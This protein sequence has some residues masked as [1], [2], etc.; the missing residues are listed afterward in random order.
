MTDQKKPHNRN[1]VHT[2]IEL[3]WNPST[4]SF[5]VVEDQWYW[6]GGAWSLAEH[7]AANI[8]QAEYRWRDDDS[9]ETGASWLEVVDTSHDF[10][11]TSGNVQARIRFTLQEDGGADSNPTAYTLQFQINGGGYADVLIDSTGVIYFNSG[12]LTDGE[13]TTSQLNGTGTFISGECSEDAITG[14]L[15][16]TANN[17]TEIEYTVEFVSAELTNGDSIDF[18]LTNTD[19]QTIDGNATITKGAAPVNY[20]RTLEST[21]DIENAIVR[22]IDFGGEYTRS[23]RSSSVVD[24][25]T[26][27]VSI[28]HIV[29]LLS[30]A[31]AYDATIRTITLGE[32]ILE[33]VLTSSVDT[34]DKIVAGVI[35]ERLLTDN[36]DIFDA[37]LSAVTV[38]TIERVIGSSIDV[39]DQQQAYE[40]KVRHL[41]STLFLEDILR[42]EALFNRLVISN[43]ELQDA[44]SRFIGKEIFVVLADTLNIQDA[45]DVSYNLT[46]AMLSLVDVLDKIGIEALYN[47]S[48]QDAAQLEDLVPISVERTRK[49][50]DSLGV[51]DEAQISRELNKVMLDVLSISDL[52]VRT[53]LVGPEEYLRVLTSN[54]GILDSLLR[55]LAEAPTI[56]A[57]LLTDNTV[58]TDELLRDYLSG[59]QILEFILV[60]IEQEDVQLD[61]EIEHIIIDIEKV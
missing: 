16:V 11:V 53:L 2:R 14:S 24:Q 29:Q 46:R 58:L 4:E 42:G 21:A 50:V 26:L 10:D 56:R 57:R 28:E 13:V 27:H 34:Y 33:R 40:N 31:S 12:N 15:S 6:Y 38:P 48:A 47:R 20:E 44:V 32:V 49:F 17:H 60:A 30:S 52:L 7:L 9:S 19:T 3:R 8:D 59:L 54:I 37:L 43:I 25:D 36:P 55:T 51:E 18:R 39:Q 1:K 35:A 23:L 41:L 61:I 5:D 45:L 22:T